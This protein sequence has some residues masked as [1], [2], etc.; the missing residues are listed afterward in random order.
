MPCS[1]L[2]LFTDIV[3]PE[4]VPARMKKHTPTEGSSI[5]GNISSGLKPVKQPYK[6]HGLGMDIDG[7]VWETMQ[8]EFCRHAI[9]EKKMVELA[10]KNLKMMWAIQRDLAAFAQAHRRGPQFL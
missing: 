1:Y 2:R 5:E 6:S 4:I 7:L 10:Q 3:Q 9:F 8:E